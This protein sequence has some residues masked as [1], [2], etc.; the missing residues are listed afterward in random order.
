MIT[1]DNDFLTSIEANARHILMRAFINGGNGDVELTGDDLIDIT[2]TEATNASDGLAMGTAISSKLVMKIKAPNTPLLLTG[3]SIRPEIT[4][5][6]LKEWIPLGKFYITEAVSNDDFATTF[7]ITAY[8]GFSKTESVY[9][10][11]IEMP[12]KAA[13]ILTDIAT[14]CGF[15]LGEV[16]AALNDIM[17]SQELSKVNTDGTLAFPNGANVEEGALVIGD[18]V[19]AS[20]KEVNS[21]TC[22]Q[23]IGYFAGLLGKNARFDRAGNLIFT[24][25]KNAEYKN[26]EGE[27]IVYNIP[28]SLQYVGGCKRLTE[29]DYSAYSITSGSSGAEIVAGTGVGFSF[30]NPFMT[31][32]ILDGIL[33][34]VG[35]ITYTPLRVKWRGNPAIEAGDIIT[36][37]DHAGNPCTVY[38]MEQTIRIGGGLNT[39]IKCYGASEQAMAFS[40]APT[41]QKIKQA[42]TKLQAAMAEVAKLLNGSNGGVFEILDEDRNGINDGWKIRSAD[43]QRF[44]KANL[45][46]IGITD[47]GGKT[48]EQAMTIDGINATAIR[49][50]TMSA[51]RISVGDE[52]L[53]DVFSVALENGHPVVTIGSSDSDI[54]QKQTN[55]AI[56]F[57]TNEDTPVAKFSTTGA[58]W[59]DLQQMKYCGF[60]WTRSPSGNVRFTKVI[61]KEGES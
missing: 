61:T 33:S 24:W 11:K 20:D 41:T 38:V 6:N 59:A 1:V 58:E 25:Y 27:T 37:E 51:Q 29:Q 30:E 8:D 2:V 35:T 28:R 60:V 4:C 18:F 48:Y 31:Q 57:V 26:A 5:Y 56:T 46:G 43:D 42:Y 15:S 47:D 13:A 54:K 45:N 36:V 23:Y 21:Y 14:Q 50:G 44:I 49:T 17:I 16:P 53:G 9:V 19:N 40:T 12:G 10:P 39:E 32:E 55:D 3:S 34:T 7:T 52:T 22:R